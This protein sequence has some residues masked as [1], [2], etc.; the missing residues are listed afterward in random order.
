MSASESF[1]TSA[2]VLRSAS[3]S[4]FTVLPSRS[5][6]LLVKAKRYLKPDATPYGRLSIHSIMPQ[7]EDA[8][9]FT[10]LYSFNLPVNKKNGPK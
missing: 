7:I 10:G 9:S 1:F 4:D 3:F 6:N 8:D 2:D 5:F